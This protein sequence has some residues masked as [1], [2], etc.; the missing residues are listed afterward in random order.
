MPKTPKRPIL[1]ESLLT[2]LKAVDNQIKRAMERSPSEREV[3]GVQKWKPI[4]DRVESVCEIIISEYGE[5]HDLDSLIVFS[6]AFVKS[7]VILCEELGLESFGEIRGAYVK[8]AIA[9][10]EDELR[11]LSVILRVNDDL[12]M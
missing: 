3:H 7:L 12:L 8:D 2:A 1:E 5:N 9:K 6:R 11:K 10:I 4:E